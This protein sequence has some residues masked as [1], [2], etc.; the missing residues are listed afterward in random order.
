MARFVLAVLMVAA[1]TAHL[2]RPAPF[3]AIVPEYLP[4]PAR[5]VL[6][7]GIFEI[8]GGIGLWVPPLRK[9]A[10]WGLVL[11]FIAV[12]PANI[13]M[14]ENNLPFGHVRSLFLAWARLPLQGVLVAWAWWFT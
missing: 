13:N 11:L 2:L 5:L 7:S 3:V 14:A 6:V 12:F 8:L 4:F 9:I 1:G 10:A